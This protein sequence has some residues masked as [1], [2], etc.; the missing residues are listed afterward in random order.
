MGSGDWPIKLLE[1][2]LKQPTLRRYFKPL[3]FLGIF[4]TFLFLIVK[5]SE[6]LLPIIRFIYPIHLSCP[7]P[8]T[9]N[10]APSWICDQKVKGLG[11]QALGSGS[12]REEYSKNKEIAEREAKENVLIKLKARLSE[13]GQASH[14]DLPSTAGD[15]IRKVVEENTTGIKID[16]HKTSTSP[17]NKDSYVLAG[18]K[19]NDLKTIQSEFKRTLSTKIQLREIQRL[20]NFLGHSVPQNGELGA[21]TVKS[22]KAFER[23]YGTPE[24]GLADT[25]LLKRLKQAVASIYQ[26]ERDTGMAIVPEMRRLPGGRF[27]MGSPPEEPEWD[28]NEDPQREVTLAPFGL[29]VNEVTFAEY[30]RFA[31]TTGRKLP[32][33]EGWGR[34]R[35]P[36]IHV[37]W[38]DA[39]AYAEWLS[40]QTGERYFLPSE[41]QWEYAARAGTTTPFAFGDCLNTDQANYDGNDDYN[42]C[43]AETGVY[44]EK[45]VSVDALAATNAYGLRH[46]HGNVWEWVKDCWHDNYWGAPIDGEAWEKARGGDCTRRVLRGGGW[47]SRPRDLRSAFRYKR[48]A[49]DTF[50]FAGF[51]LAKDWKP[52]SAPAIILGVGEMG[53]G[54]R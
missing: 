25:A 4:L 1:L 52:L 19:E 47:G 38:D 21:K 43:G 34:G 20:L 40:E 51:R 41:A 12:S 7:Y 53:L 14:K 16:I 29:M 37:G 9:N 6:S 27:M 50:N 48:I 26:P 2:V 15:F 35:R 42:G 5:F 32:D 39:A 18:I 11:I 22:I 3:I 33:D 36:V 8:D 30:D 13:V 17:N 44:R 23:S 10:P 45:T 24:T 46:M 31:G 28:G 54:L 49:T